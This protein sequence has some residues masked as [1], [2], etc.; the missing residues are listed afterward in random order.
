MPFMVRRFKERNLQRR[1]WNCLKIAEID[2]WQINVFW[3]NV[4]QNTPFREIKLL[5]WK[6]GREQSGAVVCI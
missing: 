6:E 2:L 5:R 3:V 4:S 1:I